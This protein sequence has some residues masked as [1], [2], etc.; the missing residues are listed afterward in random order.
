MMES[1]ITDLHFSSHIWMHLETGLSYLYKVNSQK[2]NVNWD[3]QNVHL[4]FLF[5]QK[6]LDGEHKRCFGFVWPSWWW[7]QKSVHT[8]AHTL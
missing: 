6:Y 5:D 3:S 7:T 4:I 8:V 1:G 2:N